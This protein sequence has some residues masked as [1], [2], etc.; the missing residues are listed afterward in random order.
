MVAL[1]TYF[2]MY[3]FPVVNS[4]MVVEK[5]KAQLATCQ[6]MCKARDKDISSV[7]RDF[8]VMYNRWSTVQKENEILESELKGVRWEKSDFEEQCNK[9]E[10]ELKKV[11]KQ[12]F[13]FEEKSRE[14]EREVEIFQQKE[15]VSNTMSLY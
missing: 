10:N 4:V 12:K 9:L 6:R 2:A 7:R 13:D 1:L 8:D 14:L 11:R 5:V 3:S 15:N